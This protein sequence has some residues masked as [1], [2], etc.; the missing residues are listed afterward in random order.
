MNV[1]VFNWLKHIPLQPVN[2][3]HPHCC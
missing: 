2:P 3:Y 1:G